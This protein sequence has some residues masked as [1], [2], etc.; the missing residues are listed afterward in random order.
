MSFWRHAIS[1]LRVWRTSYSRKPLIV[2]GARQVG[3]TT[4]VHQFAREYRQAILLNLEKPDDRRFFDQYD[5]VHDLLDAILIDRGMTKEYLADTLLFVDEI[6]ELPR[7]I[8]MLRYFY[9]EVPYLQVIAA[10]SLL[11]HRLSDVKHFPVGRISYLYLFPM[12]FC[13]FLDATG[14]Q[15]LKEAIAEVPISRSA[16]LAAVDRFKKYIMIGGMPEAV[17]TYVDTHDLTILPGVYESIW[18]SYVDDVP[19]YAETDTLSRV[20]SLI[21]RTA[22]AQLDQ[23][24]TF[25][26]FGNSNYRSREVGEGLR[27]LDDAGVIRLIYPTTDV[28]LPATPDYKKRPRL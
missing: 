11:E 19:K 16:H 24:V 21:M 7:A 5:N 14:E 3:K 23:R 12:N 8:A 2:R 4:L 1:H 13:E 20:M 15:Q 6:Q 18:A 22:P 25:E 26:R 28:Q 10:G 9:E 17:R 27:S